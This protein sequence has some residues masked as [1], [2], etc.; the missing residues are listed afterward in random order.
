MARSDDIAAEVRQLA[1]TPQVRLLGT[2][3]EAMLNV[4][5]DQLAAAEPGGPIAVEIT[6]MGGDADIGRRLALEVGLAR[7]RLNRRLVFV[8]KTAVYSAA[9]TVMGGFPR[10]DRYLTRDAV[11]LIHCRQLQR[12]L[13]LSGPLGASRVRLNQI[14]GEIEIGVQLQQEGYAALVEGS[15]VS[16]DEITAEAEAGWYVRAEE[17][18]ARGLVAGLI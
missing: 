10:E 16:L 6:S 9:T 8:G 14:L 18:L 5:Q 1:R 7:E 4:F 17:A 11:L 13:E 12:S 2:V 3:S 15:R